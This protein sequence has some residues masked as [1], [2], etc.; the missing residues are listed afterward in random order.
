[1]SVQKFR[2]QLQVASSREQQAK[3]WTLN[4]LFARSVLITHH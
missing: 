1:M 3:A 2:V 4:Y